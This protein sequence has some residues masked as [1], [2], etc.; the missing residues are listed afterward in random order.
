MYLLKT[1][2]NVLHNSGGKTL[3]FLFKGQCVSQ[4]S[5]IA[6]FVCFFKDFFFNYWGTV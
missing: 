1:N 3:D 6:F 4:G 2:Y 5:P